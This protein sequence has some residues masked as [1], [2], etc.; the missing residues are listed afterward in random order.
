MGSPD[1]REGIYDRTGRAATAK[2]Q[3]S[4]LSL[5]IGDAGRRGGHAT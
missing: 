1:L 5:A 2:R 4:T 3:A